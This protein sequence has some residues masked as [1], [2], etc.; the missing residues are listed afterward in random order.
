[1]HG[2][3]INFSLSECARL[4]ISILKKKREMNDFQKQI[5]KK[6]CSLDIVDMNELLS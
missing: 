3:S 5:Q 2:R 6:L 4:F 1:M